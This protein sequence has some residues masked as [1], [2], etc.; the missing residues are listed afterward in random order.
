MWELRIP[1]VL[2]KIFGLNITGER[3]FA[4]ASLNVR[5]LVTVVRG[6][7]CGSKLK[8]ATDNQDTYLDIGLNGEKKREMKRF[9]PD[10]IS[11]Q[12]KDGKTI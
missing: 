6:D 8:E 11:T 2:I 3:L 7:V 1:A 12:G 10:E 5:E 9:I 4:G